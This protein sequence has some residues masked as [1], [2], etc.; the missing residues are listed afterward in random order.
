MHSS[1]WECR[2]T[3]HLAPKKPLFRS[4]FP[5]FSLNGSGVVT[6]AVLVIIFPRNVA[7][8][9]TYGPYCWDC[10]FFGCRAM[11]LGCLNKDYPDKYGHYREAKYCQTKNH[12]FWKVCW[13]CLWTR[14]ARVSRHRHS[15][16][17]RPLQCCLCLLCDV[18]A[19]HCYLLVE[20]VANLLLPKF[21]QLTYNA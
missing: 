1:D 17:C 9:V 3:T 11:K 21:S 13:Q 14:V 2:R 15:C 18:Q 16:G 5:R 7:R 6:V 4:P 10:T 20:Q 12:W 8:H 19:D